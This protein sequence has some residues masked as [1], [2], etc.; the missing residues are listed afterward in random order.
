VLSAERRHPR[1]RR[2]GRLKYVFDAAPQFLAP[3]VLR[4]TPPVNQPEVS[5]SE[6]W[7]KSR[8]IKK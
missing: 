8:R 4:F 1:A 5:R 6:R 3:M 7:K 2:I